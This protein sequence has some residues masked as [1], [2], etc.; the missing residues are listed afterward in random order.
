MKPSSL[1]S[2]IALPL[3]GWVFPYVGAAQSADEAAIRQVQAQQAEAWLPR[4][5][6]W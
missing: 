5:A 3:L 2:S 4:T 6:T 1:V